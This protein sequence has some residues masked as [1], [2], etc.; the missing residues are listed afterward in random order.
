MNQKLVKENKA[1][2]LKIT[3]KCCGTCENAQ[4]I[5]PNIWCEKYTDVISYEHIC[6]DYE[7]MEN[8][9]KLYSF[10]NI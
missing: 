4:G 8:E 1:P 3:K 9:K 5:F 7:E 10:P 6:D 2:N